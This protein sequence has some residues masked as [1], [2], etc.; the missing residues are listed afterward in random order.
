MKTQNEILKMIGSYL[1]EDLLVCPI[2]IKS[3][4]DTF[5]S[6][7]C[8][9]YSYVD[10][11]RADIVTERFETPFEYDDGQTI[12]GYTVIDKYTYGREQQTSKKYSVTLYKSK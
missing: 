3:E 2:E 1:T 11:G 9:K 8:S 5:Q 4:Y 7:E 10:N 6:G 12:V